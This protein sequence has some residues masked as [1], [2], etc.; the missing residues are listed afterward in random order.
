[1]RQRDL[2][3]IVLGKHMRRNDHIIVSQPA[4]R[5]RHQCAVRQP[6]VDAPDLAPGI[7]FRDDAPKADNRS[8]EAGKP[9][10]G[11]CNEQ[12]NHRLRDQSVKVHDIQNET[13]THQYQRFKFRRVH[14]KAAV[15]VIGDDCVREID[16]HIACNP[17]ILNRMEGKGNKG[18]REYRQ[19]NRVQKLELRTECMFQPEKLHPSPNEKPKGIANKKQNVGVYECI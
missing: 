10:D 3:L 15:E 16:I 18:G 4:R 17:G 9:E 14:L 13:V 2:Q 12:E 6:D 1:M 19:K 7:T 11:T 8:G 5:K